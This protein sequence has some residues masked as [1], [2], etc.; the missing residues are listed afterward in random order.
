MHRKVIPLIIEGLKDF[1]SL[2]ATKNLF[3]WHYKTVQFFPSRYPEE[4]LY[5]YLESLNKLMHYNYIFR[6]IGHLKQ[7]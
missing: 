5:K 3:K 2:E 4:V 6:L 7:L 1:H